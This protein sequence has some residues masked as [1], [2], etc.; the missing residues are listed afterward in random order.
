MNAMQGVRIAITAFIV[1]LI[2]T[3]ATGFVW[4]GRHQ[5]VA[6]ATASRIVLLLCIV[7]GLIGART[8]WRSGDNRP[9]N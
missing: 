5:T 4:V 9:A 1:V 8:I 2:A 6:Q 7:A 3:A